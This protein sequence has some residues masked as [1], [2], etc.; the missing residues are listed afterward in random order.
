MKVYTISTDASLLSAVFYSTKDLARKALKNKRDEIKRRCVKF[1]CDTV[2]K[3]SFYFGWE[4]H[5]VTW[6]VTEIEVLE[7][8]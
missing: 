6:R 5:H 4:E 8:V 7:E 1:T 2:D 3:F